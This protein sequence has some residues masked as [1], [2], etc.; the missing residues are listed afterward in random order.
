MVECI[1]R[2]PGKKAAGFAHREMARLT[3][4]PL[5]E[6]PAERL[7]PGGLHELWGKAEDQPAE[8][9]QQTNQD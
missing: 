9:D 2:T 8:P 5:W 3:T 7:S 4:G 6:D 1:E